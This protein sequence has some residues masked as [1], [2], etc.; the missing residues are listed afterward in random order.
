[1]II[2]Q[3]FMKLYLISMFLLFPGLSYSQSSDC[4]LCNAALNFVQNTKVESTSTTYSEAIKTMFKKDYTD[5]T[6][7]K[8]AS[9][10]GLDIAAAYS[11]FS[12]SFGK[13]GDQQA[14]GS[15]YTA[16]KDRFNSTHTLASSDYQYI[17]QNQTV[18]ANL[19]KWL[20]CMTALCPVSGPVLDQYIT[21]KTQFTVSMGWRIKEA[22]DVNKSG[23]VRV[24]LT[25][26]KFVAGDLVTGAVLSPKQSLIGSFRITSIHEQASVAITI[27]GIKETFFAKVDSQQNP[28]HVSPPVVVTRLAR[29]VFI[30]GYMAYDNATEEI[31]SANTGTLANEGG[32]E[33]ASWNFIVPKTSAY[34]IE[35]LIKN[36]YST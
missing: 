21:T 8:S 20:Q 30:L 6:N 23:A 9:S 16:M 31:I 19:D 36:P 12:L 10:D 11:V 3:L 13:H 22:S 15:K 27:K 1:M 34:K 33:N 18:T 32:P 7:Y 14:S 24:L 26:C 25:N 28:D 2:N 5:W 17:F 35:M 4:V 29:E